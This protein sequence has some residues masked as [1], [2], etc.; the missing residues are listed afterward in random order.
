MLCFYFLGSALAF[1]GISAQVDLGSA[2][3]F[4]VLGGQTVTNT[5][6]SVITGDVGVSPGTAITGFPPGIIVNGMIHAGDAVALQAQIDIAAAYNAAAAEPSDVDLTG[7][8][9]GGMI[10]TPGVYSFDSSAQL[11]GILTLDGQGDSDSVWIF[12]IGTT[13]TTATS[14]SVILLN[15]ASPCNIF[16]Q[17]GSSATIGTAT[18][19]S[20]N[21][22]ALTSIT[23]VTGA[24]SNGGLYARNG[25]VTL[26][27]NRVVAGLNCPDVPP[28]TTTTTTTPKPTP[29]PTCGSHQ[30]AKCCDKTGRCSRIDIGEA[31]DADLL[32]NQCT[33]T[34]LCC[35]IKLNIK[36]SQ[37]FGNIHNKC[38]VLRNLIV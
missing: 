25:A 2:S 26:D 13:L 30:E 34:V 5:G 12:Q 9:L 11:T 7:Q 6:P 35:D 20:G 19:F 8:D 32:Y 14:A 10:L 1:T 37:I 31:K 4:A 29:K 36:D 16:W 15:G 21:I 17:V 3:S 24:S 27:T 23:V 18:T 22:L 38:V 28:P 33:G